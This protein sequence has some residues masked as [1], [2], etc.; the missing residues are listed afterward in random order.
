MIPVLLTIHEVSEMFRSTPRTIYRWVKR[1]KLKA[2]KIDKKLLF[3]EEDIKE[4]LK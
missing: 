3:K 4:L 2:V 1:G